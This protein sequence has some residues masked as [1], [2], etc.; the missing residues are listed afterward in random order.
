MPSIFNQYTGLR[1]VSGSGGTLSITP[2]TAADSPY[3]TNSGEL[4]HVDTTA[5]PVTINLPPS[6]LDGI[7]QISDVAG[8]ASTNS[9]T[10]NPN[11]T[12][13]ILG[14]TG[15][16]IT[17]NRASAVL[18]IDETQTDWKITSFNLP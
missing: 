18:S 15:L 3:T 10:V 12:D 14:D 9:I 11:G 16:I 4:L 6:G 13:T 7:L 2:V 5:G 17:T 8:Q 1:G